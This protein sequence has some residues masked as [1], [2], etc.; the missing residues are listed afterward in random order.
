MA[1]SAR[2]RTELAAILSVLTYSA[3]AHAQGTIHGTVEDPLGA[4]VPSAQVTLAQNGSN[5]GQT[6]SAADGTFAFDSLKP[7]RYHVAAESKGFAPYTSPEVSVNGSNI[8]TLKVTLETGALKQEIVV[9]AT[10]SETP[11]AQVGASVALVDNQDIQAQNK[12]DVL[13]NLRDIAGAQ[14]VQTS[15]RGGI[16]SLFIRGGESDFNKIMIDGVPANDI[17]GYFDFAQ[18]SNSG[19]SSVEVLKGANSVLYGADALAGVVNVTTQRGTSPAPELQISS[20]GGNFGSH[21]E[22]VSVSGV[23]RQFDYFGLFSR[24][25]TAGSYPNDFFHNATYVGNVGWK[26]NDRTSVRVI[27]R[28]N[29][30]DVGT[31]NGI[32]LYGIEDAATQRNDNTYLNASL[33][34]QTTSR[35]HN[36]FQF[37]YGQFNSTYIDPFQVGQIDA[38]GD[39]LGNVVTIK[40]G[41]GYSVTGQ[42]ILDYGGTYPEV[43][44]DYEAR[45]SAYWQSD[46]QLTADWT[47]TGGFR[48]EHEDGEGFTRNNYSYFIEGHGN[49]GHRLYV[50]GGL[51]L[52]NNAVFEFAAS[53]RASAAYYLRKPSGNSFISDS[54]LRF[55]FGKGIK[56]PSTYE[57]A[58][59]LWALLTPPQRSQFGVGQIGPERSQDLDAGFSQGLWKGRVRFDATY[60]HNRFYNLITY[61]DPSE[62][63]LIGINPGAAEASE[64]GAYVNASSTRAQGGELEFNSDLG[65]GFRLRAS[66]TRLDAVVTKAFGAPSYNPEFPNIP[67]GAYSPL[68]GQKPFRRAPNSGSIGLYYGHGKFVGS[69]TG[70]MVGRRDDSTFLSDQYYGNTLL[71]P[72][73][74]LDPAYQKFDLSGR[75]HVTSVVA[76]YTSMEN[77][78]SQH[79]A[80]AFGF[81]ATPFTIRSGVTLTI[82]GESW[83]R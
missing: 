39:S 19:V 46:Y 81:P 45:R 79:Y 27:Y 11:L 38:Y 28:K 74:N 73:Q 48:Y 42:G 82:G 63:I 55:N 59:Q 62:L 44:P 72:N 41:N 34:D 5:V 80:A 77:L 71:L 16:T 66:Y 4:V 67:I 51:G 6:T 24:F 23:Y 35:W 31:P 78:F 40:G 65:H 49:I 32:L 14:I 8:T 52:E 43:S 17:G 26:P 53:P 36:L 37:A 54:K 12:L 69:F 13:E 70:Y 25:D 18:L 22:S 60:F 57:Q 76:V 20:D 9:S 3:V 68:Q 47:A 2:W 64:F 50:T 15:Q 30:T 61:L 7:G 58:N 29:L 75:Y 33:Q 1:K 10:G 83:K 21:F 56:E